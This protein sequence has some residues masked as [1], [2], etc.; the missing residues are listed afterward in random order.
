MLVEMTTE[1][2]RLWDEIRNYWEGEFDRNRGHSDKWDTDAIGRKQRE[3][4]R[5]LMDRKAIPPHRFE[6]LKNPEFMVGSKKSRLEMFCENFRAS[7]DRIFEHPHWYSMRY[8]PFL[9]GVIGLP[10][11]VV[12]EFR[13]D[14]DHRT[15]NG[16]YEMG[17][18]YR[19]MAKS[20]G[21][22]KKSAD[23]FHKLALDCGYQADDCRTIRDM[24]FK[25]LR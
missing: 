20:L 22:P 7:D 25:H 5:S 17:M 14:A 13:T 16:G 1:E 24:I 11:R 4:T 3:L 23:E 10:D 19:T 2:K 21:L 15:M 8:L 18:K 9:V 6:W 12:E